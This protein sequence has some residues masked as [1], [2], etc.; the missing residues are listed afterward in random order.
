MKAPE[1]SR[2]PPNTQSS[3]EEVKVSKSKLTGPKPACP[4][5]LYGL[6]DA[7]HTF[8]PMPMHN[9]MN[10]TSIR[11]TAKGSKKVKLRLG[12]IIEAIKPRQHAL[13]PLFDKR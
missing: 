7:S 4:E 3:Q 12:N 1:M 5:N 13:R 6:S 2:N 10:E 9:A 11:G 8:P